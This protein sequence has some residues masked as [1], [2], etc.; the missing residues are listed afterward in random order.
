MNS[1]NNKNNKNNPTFKKGTMKVNVIDKEK[2]IRETDVKLVICH[3]NIR[4][5]QSE[6][7]KTVTVKKGYTFV[8]LTEVAFGYEC[9]QKKND[10]F[11]TEKGVKEL[12]ST[13]KQNNVF[14]TGTNAQ[15][16]PIEY[17]QFK[18]IYTE[19]MEMPDHEIEMSGLIG[20][21][22]GIF[23]LPLPE[24]FSE[25]R[26]NKKWK[27]L[28][29]KLGPMEKKR[30]LTPTEKKLIKDFVE[31]KDKIEKKLG[32][33]RH[34]YYGGTS[35]QT[36]SGYHLRQHK[37]LKRS[38]GVYKR[39]FRTLEKMMAPVSTNHITDTEKKRR[40]FHCPPGI[41]IITGCRNIG[42]DDEP[43]V[44]PNGTR[45]RKGTNTPLNKNKEIKKAKKL[46]KEA[47]KL[48]TLV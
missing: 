1:C 3:S 8:F 9:A 45:T 16:N 33:M 30:R 36:T 21:V 12:L 14:R 6:E 40:E 13:G 2:N 19:G 27:C 28:E 29:N 11:K 15:Y 41:Y 31:E 44:K 46:N 39:A 47:N 37:E 7:I 4:V 48:L 24:N 23:S 38:K 25:D 42:F 20:D 34:R 26:I 5:K 17:K 32:K 18:A 22:S 35:V 43:D 10:I